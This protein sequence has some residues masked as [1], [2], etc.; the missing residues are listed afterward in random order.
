MSPTQVATPLEDALTT[1]S[2]ITVTWNALITT[3]EIGGTSITSY[4]LDWDQGLGDTDGNYV[5]LVGYG[6]NSLATIFT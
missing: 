2:S 3:A 4:E 5:P 1:S 6:S